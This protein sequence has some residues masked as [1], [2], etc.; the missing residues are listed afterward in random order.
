MNPPNMIP[1][2]LDFTIVVLMLAP[3]NLECSYLRGGR[4]LEIRRNQNAGDSDR[5]G[6]ILVFALW[7][8][9]IIFLCIFVAA[10]IEVGRNDATPEGQ[11]S[12]QAPAASVV[13]Q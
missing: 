8:I 2:N 4:T 5:L 3:I 13:P 10:R 7:T 6:R 12:I 1:C 9:V 11:L